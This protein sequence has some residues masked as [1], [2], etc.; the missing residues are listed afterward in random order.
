VRNPWLF[1]LPV[2]FLVA[3]VAASCTDTDA[4]L[5]PTDV[6]PL[7]AVTTVYS[8]PE[9]RDD[10]MKGGWESYGFNN[11]GLCIQFVNTGKDSRDPLVLRLG[12]IL[13]LDASALPLNNGDPV[14]YWEDLSNNGNHA[15][16]TDQV[17]M[18]TWVSGQLNG[19]PIVRFDGVNDVL[20]TAEPVLGSS[21]T[22]FVVV[23]APKAD[24]RNGLF[25]QWIEG[26]T[27]RY[28]ASLH[29]GGAGP[30]IVPNAVKAFIEVSPTVSGHFGA[31]G[32]INITDFFRTRWVKDGTT[33]RITVD[34]ME[35][36]EKSGVPADVQQRALA[37]GAFNE[38][39]TVPGRVDIAEVIAYGKVLSTSEMAA[40]ESYLTMKYF[41]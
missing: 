13:W 35:R 12:A 25:G 38:F 40:V 41:D 5:A 26:G 22:V 37:I 2:L 20:S 36:L 15:T 33:Y 4:L 3:F 7:A 6:D 9:T 18:P 10:C 24:Q 34:G 8:D 29:E 14:A 31:T 30:A 1:R 16:Q 21:H 17:R 11:Q 27:N 28:I 23:K 32:A 39:G 19:L